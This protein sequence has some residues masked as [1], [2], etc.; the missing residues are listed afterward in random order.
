MLDLARRPLP[1]LPPKGN[2]AMNSDV[3]RILTAAALFAG[4]DTMAHAQFGDPA[5]VNG[6]PLRGLMAEPGDIDAD[7][8]PDVVIADTLGRVVWKKNLGAGVFGDP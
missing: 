4:L 2:P 5:Q 1:A 3:S 7:G 6:T 8:L